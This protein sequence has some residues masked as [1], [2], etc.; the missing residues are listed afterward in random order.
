VV[1]DPWHLARYVQAVW[2]A[3]AQGLV[4]R[5]LQDAWRGD[6]RRLLQR[7][8]GR[9]GAERDRDRRAAGEKLVAYIQAN[10]EGITNL[11]RLEATGS[12]AAEKTVDVLIV[13]RYKKRGV[14]WG[15]SGAGA[16]LHQRQLKA[17]H[18]WDA[19]WARRREAFVRRSA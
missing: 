4:G 8:K 14:S 3:A 13:H 10:A 6:V 7:V 12:G 18:Q 17:N 2:G 1:L 15:R 11:A 9:V 5:C 19:Y 16:L